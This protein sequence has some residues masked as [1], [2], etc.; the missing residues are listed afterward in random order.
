MDAQVIIFYWFGYLF[1]TFV[2]NNVMTQLYYHRGHVPFH[3]PRKFHEGFS[4]DTIV[5]ELLWF[6]KKRER[7]RLAQELSLSF[8]SV[9][10]SINLMLFLVNFIIGAKLYN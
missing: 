6:Q 3:V 10:S 5:E 1:C 7:E 9:W 8:Y 4:L 2:N